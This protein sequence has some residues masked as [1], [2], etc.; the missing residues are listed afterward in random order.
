MHASCSSGIARA[1]V[2]IIVIL[3]DL[4]IVD[5]DMGTG[6][7]M[8][9]GMDIIVPIIYSGPTRCFV[10]CYGFPERIRR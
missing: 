5:V 4:V 9:M 1:L 8:E 3:I 2:I 7:L 10:V 6:F